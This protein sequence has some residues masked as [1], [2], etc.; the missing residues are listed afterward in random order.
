MSLNGEDRDWII[1]YFE[2]VITELDR[3]IGDAQKAA[4]Q[5]VDKAEHAQE[6]RLDLL[7]E[8]REQAADESRKFALKSETDGRL[9]RIERSLNIAYGAVVVIA[10]LGVAADLGRYISPK[11]SYEVGARIIHRLA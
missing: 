8:F 4:N 10:L 3:R 1:R 6:R 9:N 11:L 5:A 2:R 7:N